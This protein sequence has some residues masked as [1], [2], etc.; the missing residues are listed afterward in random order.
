MEA[1]GGDGLL[2]E[3]NDGPGL[4]RCQLLVVQGVS[5]CQLFVVHGVRPAE[6]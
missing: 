6:V 3:E 4:S 2:R 1:V 5:R